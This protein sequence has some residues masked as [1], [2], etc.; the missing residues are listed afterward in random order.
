[1]ERL[2]VV[3]NQLQGAWHECYCCFWFYFCLCFVYFMQWSS[4]SS[5]RALKSCFCWHQQLATS[6]TM[7][8]SFTAAWLVTSNQIHAEAQC[9]Q[10]NLALITVVLLVM[11]MPMMFTAELSPPPQPPPYEVFLCVDLIRFIYLI[12]VHG[13]L[14]RGLVVSI[15]SLSCLDSFRA[16]QTT[17][18]FQPNLALNAVFS[19]MRLWLNWL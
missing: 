2:H 14:L 13:C 10:Y 7:I 19:S 17:E 6:F 16:P 12:S 8:G 4:V 1:M 15:E 9:G 18:L 11:L 3:T 5:G